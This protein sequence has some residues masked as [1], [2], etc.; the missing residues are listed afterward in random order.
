[1]LC[2]GYKLSG[3]DATYRKTTFNVIER[4][5]NVLEVTETQSG[6][7]FILDFEDV[8]VRESKKRKDRKGVWRNGETQGHGVSIT[9]GSRGWYQKLKYGGKKRKMRTRGEK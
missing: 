8:Q 4:N 3:Y 7:T 5:E 9:F 6:V 2:G 1:M